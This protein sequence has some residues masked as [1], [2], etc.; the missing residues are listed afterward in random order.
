MPF[1]VEVRGLKKI[2]TSPGRDRDWAKTAVGITGLRENFV[3]DDGIEEPYWGPSFYPFSPS[4]HTNTIE[5][6]GVCLRKRR[7]S[8]TLSRVEVFVWTGENGG[9]RK[10]LRHWQI[11]G[12]HTTQSNMARV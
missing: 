3:R 12:L 10:R 5:N 8:K 9:F 1:F 6:G 4:V 7:F 2:M 11:A